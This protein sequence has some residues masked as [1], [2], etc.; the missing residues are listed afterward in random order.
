M[1]QHHCWCLEHPQGY[2][3]S[4]WPCKT[5]SHI[6]VSSILFHNLTH[7]TKT[8]TAN[9]W[10]TTNSKP[11]GPIIV[12]GQSETM[13]SYHIISIILFSSRCT[14]LLCPLPASTHYAKNARSKPFSWAKPTYF[15]SSSSNFNG[16]HMSTAGDAPR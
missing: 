9:S 7:K 6:L 14:A 16:S 2:P 15:D 5:I 1:R 8:G 10:E 13:S 4:T 12:I 11:P 3:F